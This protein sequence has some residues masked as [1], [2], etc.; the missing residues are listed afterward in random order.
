MEVKISRRE[1]LKK[2]ALGLT[3]IAIGTSGGLIVRNILKE[4]GGFL[5]ILEN[6]SE[7]RI[8][9][10]NKE[11]SEYVLEIRDY[12]AKVG[13]NYTEWIK[14]D[15]KKDINKY[16]GADL[17]AYYTT[18]NNNQNIIPGRTYKRAKFDFSEK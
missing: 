16:D 12:T 15:M 8:Q 10:K 7:K 14:Q 3:A 13:D 4:K 9:E 11:I 1:L 17:R 2:G 5:K 6:F 18:L